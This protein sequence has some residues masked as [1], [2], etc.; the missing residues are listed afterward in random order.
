[1]SKERGLVLLILPRVYGARRG[2]KSRGTASAGGFT[3]I[4]TAE[5]TRDRRRACPLRETRI[6]TA[7]TPPLEAP[8][9]GHGVF[10][11]AGPAP[12][13]GSSGSGSGLRSISPLTSLANFCCT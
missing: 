9:G 6:G 10:G 12:P 3:R 11:V 1:M 8:P 13:A 2:V 7:L 4:E 5:A